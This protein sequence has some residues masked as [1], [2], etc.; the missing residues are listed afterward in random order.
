MTSSLDSSGLYIITVQSGP[1]LLMQYY[2]PILA[3]KLSLFHP[4]CIFSFCSPTTAS[5]SWLF[6]YI[7]C[8]LFPPYRSG[9]FNGMLEVS[10]L[11]ALNF[12]TFFC[13][14]LLTL[15]VSRNLTLTH[16]LLSGLLDSLLC[17]SIAL[18][19]DLPFS[20]SRC[21]TR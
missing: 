17:D 12:H 16:L 6:L 9:F 14:I 5:C 21:H 19:P 20:P 7:F 10:E 3:F 11:E 2:C 8:F 15:F 13:L 18:I 1:P 4:I